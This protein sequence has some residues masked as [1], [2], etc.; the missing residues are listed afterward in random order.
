MATIFVGILSL[1]G[2]LAI[3]FFDSQ[4]Q[5]IGTQT[6]A[7]PEVSSDTSSESSIT[8]LSTIS[9]FSIHVSE[10]AM[11]IPAVFELG[12]QVGAFADSAARNVDV[13]LDFGRSEIEVC[14]YTPTWAV[15]NVVAEDKSHWSLEIGELQQ[16]E[17]L[18]IRC[19][20]SSPVFDQVLISGGNIRSSRSIDFEQYRASLLSKPGGF[21]TNFGHFFVIFFTGVFCFKIIGFLFFRGKDIWS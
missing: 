14:D 20:I 5:E 19:L 9:I 3:F 7:A 4:E 15:T 2:T 1:A 6:D 16:G 17:K 10:V 18:H 12:M 8:T 21:W 11:D 13:T